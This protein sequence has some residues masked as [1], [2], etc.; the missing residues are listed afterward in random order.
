M[1]SVSPEVANDLTQGSTSLYCSIVS[2]LWRV[3]Q[4][5][6]N[7]A[8]SYSEVRQALDMS[9]N[10]DYIVNTILQ[11]FGTSLHG[12]YQNAFLKEIHPAS[13]ACIGHDIT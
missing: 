1:N 7:P 11:G 12:Q 9:V 8:L 3:L 4:S 10:R 6:E 5:N 13:T 2:S